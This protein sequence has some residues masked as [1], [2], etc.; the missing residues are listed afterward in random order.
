MV[1]IQRSVIYLGLSN[2]LLMTFSALI[3]I[4]F[5]IILVTA[6]LL[7]VIAS[8]T[9]QP[10]VIAY[11]VTGLVLGPVFLDIVEVTEFIELVEEL[12]FPML[13]F[14]IGLEMKFDAFRSILSKVGKIA[15]VQVI[16][17][18]L[19]A[20]SVAYF[21]GFGLLNSFY[22]SMCTIF[23]AT[24]VVVKMLT[25][26]HETSTRA[27]RLDIG[28]LILQDIFMV[29]VLGFLAAG[30][31]SGATDLVLTLG[32]IIFMGVALGAVSFL[33]SKTIESKLL[34][35]LSD[36]KHAFFIQGLAW[37]FLFI[38]MA[39][40]LGL[41]LEIGGFLAGIS[42]GQ[43]PYSMELQ[44]KVR[45]LTNLL[46]AVFF[47]GIGLSLNA[48][49]LFAY[50]KEAL[51]AISILS[52]SA[53]IVM[54]FLTRWQDF[55]TETS[56]KSSINLVMMSEF[57]LVAGAVAVDQGLLTAGILGYMTLIK[58]I[59][60]GY[61]VYLIQYNDRIYNYFRPYLNVVG[62]E[63]KEPD[64]EDHA[65][66]FGNSRLD[67]VVRP[68]LDEVFDEVVFVEA[69]PHEMRQLEDEGEEFV[70][71]NPRH[72]EVRREA[73][74]KDASAVIS[75][76]ED[77]DLDNEMAQKLETVFIAVS[78][79]EEEAEELMKNGAEHVIL[80]DKAVEKI[81]REKLGAKL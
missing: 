43:V 37:A 64:S 13:L 4:D 45:P 38:A 32:R 28:V 47:A 54:Y 68:L 10:T 29:V 75:L 42:L 67:E 26:K 80:E 79:D 22:I 60:N 55:S 11:L 31:I 21:L 8:R 34:G 58:L 12:G 15:V 50:W 66:V 71:G 53:F 48:S 69:N 17:Q 76:E 63:E 78:D 9:G 36:N 20:F 65:V 40:I 70:F 57:G 27:G 81:L 5:G 61:A 6:F 24:P 35:D 7:A 33:A 46:L 2:I 62:E 14:L 52:S 74:V 16:T 3:P 49:E 41:S 51:I 72:P 23:G 59:T 77:F 30:Q 25:D 73:G 1:F 39:D 44:E 18:Q 19:M 56:F